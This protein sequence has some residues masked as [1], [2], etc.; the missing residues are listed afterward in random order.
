MNTPPADIVLLIEAARADVIAAR[1]PA[2]YWF[3]DWIVAFNRRGVIRT[4]QLS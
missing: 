3:G 1:L 4:L 2:V